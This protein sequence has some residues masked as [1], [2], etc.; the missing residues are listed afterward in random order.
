MITIGCEIELIGTINKD[1]IIKRINFLNK[2]L[3][4]F[5]VAFNVNN[6]LNI[7]ISEPMYQK[8]RSVNNLEETSGDTIIN[9]STSEDIIINESTSGEMIVN[10][11]TSEDMIINEST[12]GDMIINESTSGDFEIITSISSK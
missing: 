6:N 2:Y 4:M 7:K 11:S 1:D 12:S 8:K 9:E 3:S 10:E 5:E